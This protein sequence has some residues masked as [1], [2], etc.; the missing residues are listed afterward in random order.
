MRGLRR[1]GEGAD[2]LDTKRTVVALALHG[3]DV[4]WLAGSRGQRCAVSLW[5]R[6][7]GRT[8]VLPL[9]RSVSAARVDDCSVFGSYGFA[10]LA[11]AGTDVAWIVDEPHEY[12][13]VHCWERPR[14]RPD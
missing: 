4:A 3:N 2:V 6:S 10:A 12:V 9:P 14:Q 11:L 13:G 8:T 7:S 1:L 5:L